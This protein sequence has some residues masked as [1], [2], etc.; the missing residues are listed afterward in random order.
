M[1]PIVIAHQQ[2]EGRMHFNAPVHFQFCRLQATS[3]TAPEIFMEF[4]VGNVEVLNA[5]EIRLDHSYVTGMKITGNRLRLFRASMIFH[6]AELAIS[7]SFFGSDPD[8]TELRTSQVLLQNGAIVGRRVIA[9]HI[10]A[11]RSFLRCDVVA[12]DVMFQSAFITRHEENAF[13]VASATDYRGYVFDVTAAPWRPRVRAGCHDF[14]YDEALR[15]WGDTPNE[16]LVRRLIEQ[17]GRASENYAQKL[18]SWRNTL[19][20][21]RQAYVR[22]TQPRQEQ[23][24]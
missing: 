15:H 17:A 1:E 22:A 11:H 7:A 24:A 20:R 10:H 2:V 5:D 19:A 9:N 12:E 6:E 3:I 14:T 18:D 16:E 13:P 21:L 4:S 23:P 8:I